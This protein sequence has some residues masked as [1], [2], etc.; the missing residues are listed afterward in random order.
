[1]AR[2]SRAQRGEGSIQEII[3]A[4]KGGTHDI[5][6][7]LVASA[8]KNDGALS[9]AFGKHNAKGGQHQDNDAH[10]PFPKA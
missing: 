2:A 7:G 5:G 3:G 9:D 10:V 1:M 8:D 4:N 6:K